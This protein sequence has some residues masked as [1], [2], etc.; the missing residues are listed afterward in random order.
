MDDVET[1]VCEDLA[2]QGCFSD[3]TIS[4]YG[5]CILVCVGGGTEG[6]DKM[7]QGIWESDRVRGAGGYLDAP[8]RT[9]ND[10]IPVN[11]LVIASSSFGRGK[12]P[13]NLEKVCIAGI[14]AFSY[15]SFISY[16]QPSSQTIPVY[17]PHGLDTPWSRVVL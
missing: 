13:G 4:Y 1:G 3:A 8:K 6:M 11:I 15:A 12:Y 16:R 7:V 5:S 14:C 9:V 2:E 10:G 17:T